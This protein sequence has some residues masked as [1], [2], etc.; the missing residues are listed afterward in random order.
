MERYETPKTRRLPVRKFSQAE[1][2]MWRETIFDIYRRMR[3]RDTPY[4]AACGDIVL[5]ALPNVYAPFFFTDSQWFGEHVSSIVGTGSL[6]EIGSGSGVISVICALNGARV[7][8]TDINP[9][10]VENTRIN[11]EKYKLDIDVRS[12]DL[13]SPLRE[14]EKF[15]YIFWAHPFNNWET[16]VDD[17]LLRSGMDFR[18]EG[19]RGYIAGAKA[20]LRPDGR[21]L[22]GTGDS[23]DLET[24]EKIAI[25]SGYTLK[26]L[27]E[28]TMPLELGLPNEIT[29]LIYEL[30]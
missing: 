4:E 12:G 17:I 28:A 10:A 27:R 8:A 16:P 22:L 9:A 30:G 7:T 15:E 20:H 5:T 14:S 25:E 24:I 18:Y 26:L 1:L 13:Y 23:A 2:E 3:Q 6:L 11:A 19:I 29:Y 21:L